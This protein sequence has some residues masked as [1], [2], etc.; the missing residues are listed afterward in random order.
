ME[1]A[2]VADDLTGAA[3]AS[4]VFADEGVKTTVWL[5]E[6]KGF[7]ENICCSVDAD[8]RW[9]ELDVASRLI[10][11]YV[12]ALKRSR[13]LMLKI[14]STLRGFVGAMVRSAWEA[15]GRQWAL[16]APAVPKQGRIVK[17]GQLLVHGKLVS[18]TNLAEEKPAPI[19]S[20]STIE[21]LLETGFRGKRLKH[22]PLT[23][24]RQ[25]ERLTE[26]FE[27][28]MTN[29]ACLVCDAETD[30]DLGSIISAAM[31]EPFP[32]LLVGASGLAEALSEAT[33]TKQKKRGFQALPFRPK[34]LLIVVGSQQTLAQRQ[35]EFLQ[36]KG[37]PVTKASFSD[38]PNLP[39]EPV[40]AVKFKVGENLNEEDI[41]KVR[42]DVKNQLRK[43][44]ATKVWDALL[45]VGGLT[46]RLIFEALKVKRW[47]LVGSLLPGMP[48]GL[49]RFGECTLLVATK[50]GGFGNEQ[51]L[52]Q[53]IDKLIGT[54]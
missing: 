1:W 2:I 42:R 9:R 24:V 8:V 29:K 21:R 16:V 47:E 23:K 25:R 34:R 30:K 19:R 7:A 33:A 38:L 14:D 54:F 17:N 27:W 20:A 52:W 18:E 26:A 6:P 53:A 37:V 41:A 13:W 32:P 28:A 11:K 40:L 35:L 10:R 48:L 49:V 22:I 46:A 45:I 50:A 12:S 3:D 31:V 44:Q 43:W 39:T 15:S 4:V 51:T 36:T 5:T